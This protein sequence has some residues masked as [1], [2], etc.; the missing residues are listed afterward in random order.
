[1]T[2]GE[3]IE[4]K[5]DEYF[6][7]YKSLDEQGYADPIGMAKYDLTIE[8]YIAQEALE[9]LVKSIEG[10]EKAIAGKGGD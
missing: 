5:V 2:I 10:Y 6:K 4:Q 7:L 9:G 8:K 3:K 1:M